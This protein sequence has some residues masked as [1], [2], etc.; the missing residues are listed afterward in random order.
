[1]SSGLQSMSSWLVQ[2]FLLL[3]LCYVN[4][5]FKRRVCRME[6]LRVCIPVLVVRQ[7]RRA[8]EGTE[9]LPGAV[10]VEENTV[11]GLFVCTSF[12]QCFHQLL[13]MIMTLFAGMDWLSQIA[14]RKKLVLNVISSL[15]VLSVHFAPPNSNVAISNSWSCIRFKNCRIF[16]CALQ[17][18]SH[19]LRLWDSPIDS[20]LGVS[21][22]FLRRSLTQ[23]YL[24]TGQSAQYVKTS[25]H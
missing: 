23:V 1:M 11:L 25:D 19:N 24:F 6:E 20:R 3:F 16:V 7:W 14:F 21:V 10:S 4:W 2:V 18:K 5:E 17:E 8:W 9:S 13:K 15:W 12:C 22:R